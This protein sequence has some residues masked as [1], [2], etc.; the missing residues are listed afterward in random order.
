MARAEYKTSIVPS[1]LDR[2]LDDS[3]GTSREPTAG[4]FQT[5][6]EL[7]RSVARDLEALLNTRQETLVALPEEFVEVNRSLLTYG[8][9]DFTL[10]SLDSDDDRSRVRRVVEQAIAEFEPRLERV[11]VILQTSRGNERGLRFRIDAL[12]KVDPAPEPVTFD[13]VL[14]LSTQQYIVKGQE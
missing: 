10:F 13:A 11:Q 12:L 2:L 4:G 7:E 1:V 5:V 6:R 3:P 14:Q 8:L 9:P